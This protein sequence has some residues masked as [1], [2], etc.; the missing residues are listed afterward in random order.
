MVILF[1]FGLKSRVL[2]EL[3][4]LKGGTS[5]VNLL[6]FDARLPE[7]FVLLCVVYSLSCISSFCSS[8]VFCRQFLHVVYMFACA[9]MSPIGP[10]VTPLDWSFH[11]FLIGGLG[12]SR[13]LLNPIYAAAKGPPRAW[14]PDTQPCT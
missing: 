4:I 3:G 1:L 6:V 14:L 8:Y 13:M 11:N 5:S 10:E 12:G 2:F 7:G 9:G